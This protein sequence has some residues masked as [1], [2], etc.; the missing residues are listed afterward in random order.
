MSEGVT[1]IFSKKEGTASLC[2]VCAFF[3]LWMIGGVLDGAGLILP[4]YLNMG[5]KLVMEKTR[6]S[7]KALKLE[8]ICVVNALG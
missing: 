3:V 8:Y 7:I 5:V 2:M 4:I 6:A 1:I